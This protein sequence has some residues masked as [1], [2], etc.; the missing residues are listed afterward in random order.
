MMYLQKTASQ[1]LPQGRGEEFQSDIEIVFLIWKDTKVQLKSESDRT[2][3]A[4]AES[5][6]TSMARDWGYHRSHFC[7]T[8]NFWFGRFE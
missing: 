7:Q 3:S 5:H 8:E 4:E 1:A 6:V 2:A